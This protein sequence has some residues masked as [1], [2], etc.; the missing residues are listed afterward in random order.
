[1]QGSLPKG[2]IQAI[3]SKQLKKMFKSKE[4]TPQGY[5]CVM[6]GL[7]NVNEE[8][9]SNPIT[10]QL[11]Q[12]IEDYDDVFAEP[13]GLP[14]ARKQD[15]HI[16]LFEGTQPINQRSYKVPYIQKS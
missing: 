3:N 2:G 8:V 11:Q 7:Q 13:K 5:I 9:Q 12:L 15:H 16:P 1:M 4:A 6:S 10:P 14:L